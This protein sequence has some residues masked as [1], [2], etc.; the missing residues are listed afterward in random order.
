LEPIL[1]VGVPRFDLT[2]EIART[3]EEVFAYLTDVSKLPEWQTSAVSAESD[4]TVREGTRIRERR[5]FAGRDVRTELE[6][7]AYEPPMRFDVKS[8][9]GP[10][11]FAIRHTLE[12]RNGGTHLAV[13][14]NV[15]V[16]AM[17]RI[18]A[19]GPLKVAER[20]F[21]SDFQRLKE[22]LERGS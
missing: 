5:K 8:R 10:V 21:R 3:A 18:A 13:D 11:S 12:P 6:V 19:A 17:L 16:G 20:E 9:A 22:I 14:V 1:S 15:K 7:V 2:V 4:G